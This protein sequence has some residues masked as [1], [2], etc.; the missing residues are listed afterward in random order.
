MTEIMNNGLLVNK[1]DIMDNNKLLKPIYETNNNKLKLLR[2]SV[3]G[4]KHWYIQGTYAVADVINENRRKYG[5]SELLKAIKTYIENRINHKSGNRAIGELGHPKEDKKFYDIDHDNVAHKIMELSWEGDLV[6]GKSRINESLPKASTVIGLLEDGYPYA[7]SLRGFG[8]TEERGKFI[9]ITDLFILCWD[10]V[11][12]PGFGE[13]AFM[14]AVLEN[15]RYIVSGGEIVERAI[16][17]V[18]KIL[19][20]KPKMYLKEENDNFYKELKQIYLSKLT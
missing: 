19:S 15:K 9:N 17:D 1:G 20:N 6:I 8:E 7:V 13:Y 18:E 5:K 12:E 14:D 16:K 10:L 4:Q 3:N 2:E 11:D